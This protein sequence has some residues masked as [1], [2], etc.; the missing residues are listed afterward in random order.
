L[1]NYLLTAETR[2]L[3]RHFQM[4]LNLNNIWKCHTLQRI[5][6]ALFFITKWRKYLGYQVDRPDVL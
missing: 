5:F 2:G 1:K 3:Y 6:F 4:L